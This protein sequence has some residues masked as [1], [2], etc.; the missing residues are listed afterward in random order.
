[1]LSKLLIPRHRG[2][3]SLR[4]FVGHPPDATSPLRSIKFRMRLQSKK[5]SSSDITSPSGRWR[6]WLTPHTGGQASIWVRS[7]SARSNAVAMSLRRSANLCHQIHGTGQQRTDSHSR[8]RIPASGVPVPILPGDYPLK[9]GWEQQQAARPV[10][11]PQGYFPILDDNYVSHLS[12]SR[13]I[14]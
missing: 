3:L 10:A 5:P 14:H 1:M 6:L 11:R 8:P 4:R 12:R 9:S 13:R 2:G 7:P